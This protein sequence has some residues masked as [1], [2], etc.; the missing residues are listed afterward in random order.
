MILTNTTQN[1]EG[2]ITAV[3]ATTV[4]ATGVTW[5]NL[6]VFRLVLANGLELDTVEHY[7]NVA[8]SDIHVALHSAAACDCNWESWVTNDGDA[9]G[10]LAKLNI[11]DAASYYACHCGQPRFSDNQQARYLTWMSQQLDM[12]VTG[13]LELCHGHTGSAFPSMGW[14]EQSHTD[15]QA[16]QIIWNDIL[17]NS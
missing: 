3:T 17:R 13:K 15:F 2:P 10:L 11:I 14:A 7:L 4:T 16:A 1:T 5:D 8:S 6:D 9:I 12:I